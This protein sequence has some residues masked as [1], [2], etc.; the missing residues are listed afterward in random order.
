[1][2]DAYQG[3]PEAIEA[4]RDVANAVYEVRGPMGDLDPK[5]YRDIV[6][7]V[8]GEAKI[9]VPNGRGGSVEKTFGGVIKYNGRATSLPAWVSQE[10]FDDVIF[11]VT[12]NELEHTGHEK[13]VTVSQDGSPV[14][15][16][17]AKV[18]GKGSTQLEPAPG[19]QGKYYVTLNGERGESGEYLMGE[20][21]RFVLD[22]GK[23]APIMQQNPRLP[24]RGWFHNAPSWSVDAVTGML[25]APPQY[26]AADYQSVRTGA[27]RN[28]PGIGEGL[29]ISRD[30]QGRPSWLQK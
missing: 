29:T 24:A 1:L 27:N 23:L 22:L 14:P 28:S 7:Q 5:M 13:P 26:R 20:N 10:D 21:G 19:G 9:A 30:T 4:V 16:D 17:I 8:I 3:N 18:L 11:H 15:V 25:Q 2:G 12:D 6:K